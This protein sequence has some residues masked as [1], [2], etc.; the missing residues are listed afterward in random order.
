MNSENES[1]PSNNFFIKAYERGSVPDAEFTEKDNNPYAFSKTQFH[2]FSY[3]LG[4]KRTGFDYYNPTTL[5]S[6]SPTMIPVDDWLKEPDLTK[7]SVLKG[8][9]LDNSRGLILVDKEI[10]KKFSGLV[11]ELLAQLLSVAMGKKVSLKVRLFEPQ[12]FLQRMTNYWAFFPRFITPSYDAKMSAIERMKHA[13]AFGVSGLYVPTQ[14][15]KPFNPLISETFEGE[16]LNDK[17]NTKIYLEQISNYPTVSR[18]YA[19][20][21][22]M[23][24]HGYLDIAV[25]TEGLGTKMSFLTKGEVNLEYLQLGEKITY[26]FPTVRMLKITS[27]EGRSTYWYNSMVF[28]DIKNKLKGIIRLGYNWNC[29]QEIEGFIIEFDYPE[30]YKL[31]YYKE[32][33]FGNK[34]NGNDQRYKIIAKCKGSW[35][36]H[37]QFEDDDKKIWDI[38]VDVPSWIKPVRDPIPSDGR[39]REDLMWLY[40]SFHYAKNEEERL[41]YEAYAQDFKLTLEKLQREE[42]AMKLKAQPKKKRFFGLI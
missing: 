26:I 6:P 10:T 32:Q 7:D 22:E 3:L 41:K 4:Q 37:L 14:Q 2:P 25:H 40:R 27:E 33:T 23:K 31:D 29:I 15:L 20:N 21:P 30:N 28:I 19:I 13:M 16:F 18:F 1:P 8:L 39:Y 35:V 24:M 9:E 17:Y 34:F 36:S 5:T 11:R 12:S 42:R 38:D